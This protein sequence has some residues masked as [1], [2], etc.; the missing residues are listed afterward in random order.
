M[1]ITISEEE[2]IILNAVREVVIEM[3]RDEDGAFVEAFLD[4]VRRRLGGECVYIRKRKGAP[5]ATN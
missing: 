3:L 5:G 4:R 1:T 2:E